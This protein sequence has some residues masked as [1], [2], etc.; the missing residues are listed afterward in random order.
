VVP[1]YPVGAKR[2][3]RDNG[4][5]ARTLKT[6]NV[7]LVTE[8]IERVTPTGSSWPTAPTTTST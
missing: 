1:N 5:W 4:I 3:V 7:H 2:M 6:P 8:R